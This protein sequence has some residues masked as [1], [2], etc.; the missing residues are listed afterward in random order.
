M[1]AVCRALAAFA[2]QHRAA[3]ALGA[4]DGLEVHLCADNG[5]EV[6]LWLGPDDGIEC[7]N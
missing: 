1:A 6:W 2:K 7:S 4:T 3:L 5:P